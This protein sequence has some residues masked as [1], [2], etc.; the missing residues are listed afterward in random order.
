[1]STCDEH[2][3]YTIKLYEQNNTYNPTHHIGFTNFEFPILNSEDS[4]DG[5][6]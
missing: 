5:K 2:N 3:K 6:P 1:M 4:C